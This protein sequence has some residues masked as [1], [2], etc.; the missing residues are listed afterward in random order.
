MGVYQTARYMKQTDT[1]VEVHMTTKSR[2]SQ[3]IHGSRKPVPMLIV[4]RTTT[5]L[6]LGYVSSQM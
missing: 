6:L 4:T 5:L 3:A 1:A 2:V